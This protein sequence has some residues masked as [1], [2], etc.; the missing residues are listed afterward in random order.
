MKATLQLPPA[1]L[2][3]ANQGYELLTLMLSQC[4]VE[5]NPTRA[6]AVQFFSTLQLILQANKLKDLKVTKSYQ[7]ADRHTY[8]GQ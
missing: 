8:D 4:N 5:L 7:M 2:L 3:K 6:E 1:Y